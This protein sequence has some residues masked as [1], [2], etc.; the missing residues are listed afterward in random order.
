MRIKDWSISTQTKPLWR[1][2]L[3]EPIYRF[4]LNIWYTGLFRK[5]EH[6]LFLGTYRRQLCY[7]LMPCYIMCSFVLVGSFVNMNCGLQV[8]LYVFHNSQ[9][10]ILFLRVKSVENGMK[11]VIRTRIFEKVDV[12]NISL[13]YE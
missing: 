6:L 5:R 7:K 2:I 8:L 9:V 10:Y 1:T 13:L 4:I 11:N 3:T 12:N